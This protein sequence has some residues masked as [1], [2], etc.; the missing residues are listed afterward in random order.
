[1]R[2]LR[3]DLET[4]SSIDLKKSGNYRYVEAPDFEILLFG[5]AFD[6]DPVE[7]VDLAN[8]ESIPAPVLEAL[9]DPAF[10]KKAFNAAFERVCLAK[11]FGRTMPP[12][13]WRCTAVQALYF[14]LPNNLDGV[15]KV[16]QL[17]VKK[18]AKGKN[19]IKYFSVPCKETKAN[20]FRDR[21]YPED[22][23]AKWA[24]F[25][26]YC[27]VD[28]EVEREIDRKLSVYPMP[29]AEWRLW[30]LDQEINDR[31][32]RLDRQMVRQAIKADEQFKAK[33][34]VEARELTK[35]SNPNSLD[36]LKAWLTS[37][38]LTVPT[39]SAEDLPYLLDQVS[40]PDVLRVLQLR[41]DLAKTSVNKYAAMTRTICADDR[42]RGL[43]QFYGAARTGRHAGRLIQ[44]HNLP[45]NNLDDLEYARELLVAGELDLLEFLYGSVA[46]V[47][48]QLLRTALTASPGGRL[49]VSDFSAIEARVLAWLAKETWR[50]KVFKTHG[51]IYE[52]SAAQMFGVPFESI[53]KTSPLRQRGKVAELALGYQGGVK[54]LETMDDKKELN[55]DEMPEIVASWREAN[56]N[57]VQYWYDIG[58]AAIKAVKEKKTVR[59]D[60][61]IEFRYAPGFL[62]IRLPSGRELAYVNPRVERG[63]YDRPQLSY[64]GTNDKKQW[65]RMRTYGGRLVENITQAVAR[66]CLMVA[67]DRVN[68]AG[69]PIVFH[70]HDEV[71]ADAPNGFGSIGHLTEIMGAPIDWAPELPLKAAG[72]ETQF[73]MKD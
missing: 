50:L 39:L 14:G 43:L 65:V 12:E 7:V 38:G 37:R 30:A 35:L 54:A 60:H 57:I 16:L 25:I 18:D 44:V 13:Q 34:T 61:G 73:Y 21:N 20:G 3:I 11:H 67:L 19:L 4:F 36:Q 68:A 72:F 69:Y 40:D 23:P 33:L 47:L 52:A 28:V 5:Y 8:Y 24:E 56:P 29:A 6:D 49:I 2:T 10:V 31:G 45:R 64:E 46:D 59:M 9:F 32:V 26:A 53:T 17:D 62:F 51:K 70:V 42:A 55:P 41:Q 1:M 58:R 27:K 15:A 22:S 71:V 63:D 66:D 48:S